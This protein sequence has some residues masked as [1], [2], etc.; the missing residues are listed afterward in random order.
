MLTPEKA[1]ERSATQLFCPNI[2]ALP[3]VAAQVVNMCGAN[4]VWLLYGSMGAG[5]T[6]FIKAVAQH[7]GVVDTVNSPTFSLVNEYADQQGQAYYHFD[8]YRIKTEAEAFDMG[9]EEY[10]DSGAYCFVEWPQQIP[11]FVPPQHVSIQIEA[12]PQQERTF[13]ITKYE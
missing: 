8:F 2:N 4:R 10:F 12:G 11:S 1:P 3:Q 5:K 13:I 7:L 6:T 9:I